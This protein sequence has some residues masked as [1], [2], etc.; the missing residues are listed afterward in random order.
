VT[1]RGDRCDA[2]GAMQPARRHWL[3]SIGA[4]RIMVARPAKAGCGEGVA[5]R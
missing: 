3:E 4:A 5:R 1:A 2:A